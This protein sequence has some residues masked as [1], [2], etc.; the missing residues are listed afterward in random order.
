MVTNGNLV[1]RRSTVC[2]TIGLLT[3]ILQFLRFS[4]SIFQ[5]RWRLAY[6]GRL[7]R[8]MLRESASRLIKG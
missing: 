4:Q 3:I 7:I 2:V 6:T 1:F 8:G 5:L